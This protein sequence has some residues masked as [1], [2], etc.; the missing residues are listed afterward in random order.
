MKLSEK[1]KCGLVI[2]FLLAIS[3]HSTAQDLK[4]LNDEEQKKTEI[5]TPSPN[6]H[7]NNSALD[8]YEDND[9]IVRIKNIDGHIA[10]IDSKIEY[11]RNE[12]KEKIKAEKS[13]WFEQMERIKQDLLK[14]KAQLLLKSDIDK[15]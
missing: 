10:A 2:F 11:V 5:S 1:I 9:Y 7:N 12:E 4:K 8:V 6:Y 3:F 13:G 15:N 14:E